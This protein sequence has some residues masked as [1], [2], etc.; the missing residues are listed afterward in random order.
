V[1]TT[2]RETTSRRIFEDAFVSVA[3][4]NGVRAMQGYNFVNESQTTT[5]QEVQEGVRKS[6]AQAAIVVT[7]TRGTVITESGPSYTT[8]GP[9]V[10][11][12]DYWGF[13]STGWMEWNASSTTETVTAQL[14]LNIYDAGNNLLVWSAITDTVPQDQ[15]SNQAEPIARMFFKALWSRSIL[16]P[17]PLG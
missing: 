1:L 4:S 17:A 2:M 15:L 14:R 13:Y 11:E 12:M 16:V 3:A 8:T 10:F 5:A 7:V 9:P 6:G